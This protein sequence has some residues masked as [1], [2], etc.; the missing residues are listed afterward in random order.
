MSTG[1]AGHLLWGLT[2]AVL[3]MLA[4]VLLYALVVRSFFPA[5]ESTPPADAGEPTG[6]IIQVEVRNGCGEAGVAETLTRF[7][8]QRGF[9]VV[10]VG[11]HTTFDVAETHVIDRVGAP[12]TARRVA[13][14][15][16]VA[17]AQIREDVRPQYFLDATIVI[18]K[19]YATLPPF[20]ED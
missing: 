15:L 8:R 10:E 17:E 20:A 14:A 5:P 18:G 12:E 6:A 13:E 7:L 11:N 3:G 2:V 9:D 19:D 16:G 4:L 1:R